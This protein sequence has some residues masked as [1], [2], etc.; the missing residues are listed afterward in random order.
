MKNEPWLE[1]FGVATPE[2]DLYFV[3]IGETEAVHPGLGEKGQQKK[4]AI[5][6]RILSIFMDYSR[7]AAADDSRSVATFID[8]A[9]ILRRK[10]RQSAV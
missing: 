6:K 1:V 2:L 4:E 10:S 8:H 7:A 9:L 5:T 3:D